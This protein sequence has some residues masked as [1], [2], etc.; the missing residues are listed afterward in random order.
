MADKENAVS[1]RIKVILPYL[2]LTLAVAI[3]GVYVVT[4]LVANSLTERL[5]N[6]LLQAARVVSD[7][8]A[9][10]EIKHVENA[11]VIAYTNGLAEALMADDRKA[12]AD[13][14]K[15][16]AA[17]LSVE[18]LILID[19]Q[20]REA[21]HL[22]QASN[23]E[24]QAAEKDTGGGALPIVQTILQQ[25]NPNGQ[26]ERGLGLDPVDNQYHY[27]TALPI[28]LDSQV[29]G[30]IVVGT[31][32]N[33]FLPYLKST[34][35]ADLIIYAGDGQAIGSTL[36]G[37]EENSSALNNLTIPASDYQ[38]I[39]TSNDIVHGENFSLDG[40]WY[41]LA[42]SALHVGNSRLGAFAVVLPLNFVL[43]A[44][45]VSRNTYVGIFAG[46][47]LAVV[48]IGFFVT[49]VIINPLYSLVHTSKAI[50]GGDLKQRTGIRSRD[51]I[52]VLADTFDSMTEKLQQRTIELEKT[53]RALEQMDKTKSMFISISAHELRTPLTLISGYAQMIPITAKNDPELVSMARNILEGA[54]RMNEIVG[55]MLDVSKI[56]SKTLNVR[57]VEIQLDAIIEKIKQA[58]RSDLAERRLTLETDHLSELPWIEADPEQLYKVFYHLI[59]NAI[60]YTPDGGQI[61]VSGK[62]LEDHGSPEVEV[63][64]K[65]SGI[66]I[67]PQHQELVFEKFYQTGEVLLHSTGRTKFKGGGPGLGLA[68][69]RGIV[70]AHRGS[71]WV[72]SSG[73]DEERLPGS[74][75]HVRLPVK[76]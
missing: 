35:L 46:A 51:E 27:F 50:A 75:F 61:S 37:M 64:I 40:R 43:Q 10:Q 16:T 19:P 45:A 1:I 44:G 58:F 30:V 34:S 41:S 15:P 76:G 26:P 31:S 56:D 52:G 42:R 13:L 62:T 74:V 20:G 59:I 38:Q 17:G 14:A 25:N 71:I 53:N 3:T 2:L 65:D 9:R 68:I 32:L 54:N 60:K 7:D 18:D 21:L 67:D 66:G 22:V 8:F 69:A 23:G 70:A 55:N 24:L 6:Q 57:P 11:R 63:I 36:G 5:N 72:E 28:P 47:M 39:T 73:H 33:T 4:K 48:L 12:V 29:A 49:R